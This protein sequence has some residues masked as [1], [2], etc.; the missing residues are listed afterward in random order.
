MLH[1]NVSSKKMHKIFLEIRYKE[2]F[3]LPENKFKILDKLSNKFTDFD[4]NQPDRITMMDSQKNIIVHI[5]INRLT[6]DWEQPPSIRDF[7][8]Y[9][10]A[11]IQTI[12]SVI[13]IEQTKRIGI[14]TFMNFP[15]TSP[16]VADQY[17]MNRYFS[18]NTRPTTD[19]A[20]DA[21]NARIQFSGR[22]GSFHFNL[23]IASTQEQIIEGLISEPVQAVVNN[24]LTYDVDVYRE[25]G[26]NI[27][28]L[29]SFFKAA[30]EF[31]DIKV[32]DF[33][34]RVEG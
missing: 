6:I 26:I 20:D 17:I 2:I 28:N 3:S 1:L 13:R 27:Q 22:K 16:Q 7:V 12:R 29:D 9:A 30:I 4:I 33:I 10:N 32:I 19:L 34:K 5:F 23:A 14:R 15:V 11:L 25:S 31:V 18:N 21:G 24:Y 8:K